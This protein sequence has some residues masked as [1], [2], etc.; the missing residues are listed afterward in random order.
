MSTRFKSFGNN[1]VDACLLAF[2]GEFG[3]AHYVGNCH[4][5][6]LQIAGPRLG[7]AGRCENDFYLFFDQNLHQSLY[8][9]IHQRDVDT[10]RSFGRYL[11]FPDMLA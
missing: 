8:L 1:G 3:T 7:V 2:E 11:T 6:F 9:R 10:K 4:A 5:V